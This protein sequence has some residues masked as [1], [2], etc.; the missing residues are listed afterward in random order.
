M[1]QHEEP[2]DPPHQ[3]ASELRC[4]RPVPDNT[5]EQSVLAFRT[6]PKLLA[7][8]EGAFLEED[9]E[10]AVARYSASEQFSCC[11]SALQPYLK[12]D[13]RLLDLGAGRGLTSVAFARQGVHVTSVECDPSDIV[14]IG[15]LAS[16]R[17]R[18]DLP[19]NPIRGDILQLPFRDETFDLAFSRSVLHHLTD[20]GQ[21]LKEVWRI[22]KP[23]GVFIASS[24]HIRSPFSDGRKFLQAHPSVAFGVNERAYPIFTYWWKFRSAGFRPLRFFQYPPYIFE[25]SEF[26]QR[27]KCK[28]LTARWVRLP[29]I[30]HVVARLLYGLHFLVYRYPHYFLVAE[31]RLPTVNVLALKP[32]LGRR[33]DRNGEW[34][35]A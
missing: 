7:W 21:G 35:A 26:L 13:S 16:F 10:R 33:N 30:G 29:R 34:Q 9:F 25:F 6:D 14:G 5:Y 1:C 8:G 12:K 27:A 15:A 28:A 19:L 2:S 4:A 22:L 23:G 32:H 11:W 31:E 24:E 18:S 3:G 17:R 20:L